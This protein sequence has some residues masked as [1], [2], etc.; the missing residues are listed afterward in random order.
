MGWFSGR[1]ALF[2]LRYRATKKP[3]P[4][5]TM[6]AIATPTPIPALPPVLKPDPESAGAAEVKSAPLEVVVAGAD[7]ADVVEAETVD[8]DAGATL[9][10]LEAAALRLK[11]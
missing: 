7:V 2:C 6:T 4:T 9:E 1:F 8:V 11:I 10:E 3:A 5:P